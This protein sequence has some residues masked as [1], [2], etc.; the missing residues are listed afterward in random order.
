MLRADARDKMPVVF[1]RPGDRAEKSLGVI[2]KCNPT[3]AKVRLTES[4]GKHVAGTLYD[5]PYSLMEPAPV[6]GNKYDVKIG[7]DT[8]IQIGVTTFRAVHADT[9]PLWRVVRKSGREA[10]I[11]RVE[12]EQIVVN[13]KEYDG[14]YAGL[15]KAFTTREIRSSLAMSRAFD[16]I[17]DE[18]ARF[19]A[20]LR[21]GQIVHYHDGFNRY[22]RCEV[23]QEDGKNV[24]KRLALVGNWD[25]SSLPRRLAD[26]SISHHYHAKKIADGETF[27]AHYTNV[28][29][30]GRL[31]V[32]VD[33]TRMEP[34]DLT[35]PE[36]T[37][38]E[39]RVAALWQKVKQIKEIAGD[40][41]EK[42]PNVLL[43]KIRQLI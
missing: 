38:E 2:E 20:N 26:G 24:L 32:E 8:D 41:T 29:E 15:E 16:N 12:N 25:P 37:Q 21:P 5:V 33:P 22:V 34:I 39:K 35:L 7:G 10:Y 28:Y 1:G 18:D 9:R 42:D 23:E 11:C 36:P 40:H 13:G 14:E 43:D 30:S 17:H 19:Y 4:R 3:R 6:D 31:K 27:R